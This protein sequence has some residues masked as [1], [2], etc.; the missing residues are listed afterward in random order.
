MFFILRYRVMVL[1]IFFGAL[2]IA[3]ALIL[4]L[5]EL[6]WYYI[7]GTPLLAL[8]IGMLSSFL[9]DTVW[10]K[11]LREKA[12]WVS[13][14]LG[15]LFFAALFFH[16]RVYNNGSF[17]YKDV[18]GVTRTYIKGY[19]YTPIAKKYKTANPALSSDADLLYEGFGGIEG[20]SYVWTQAS[21]RQTTFQ[22]I[23]S[24]GIVILFLSALLSWIIG[25]AYEKR[26]LDPK[27]AVQDILAKKGESNYEKYERS[28]TA[29]QNDEKYK[30]IKFHVFLSYAS[31]ERKFAE[32]V[33]YSLT[34]CGYMVFFDRN[35]LPPGMEY[36]AAIRAAIMSSDI[37]IFMISPDSVTEGH[38]TMSELRF[39]REKW[40]AASGFLLPVMTV[41]TSFDHIPAYAKSVTVLTPEGSLVAEVTAEVEK[42][43]ESRNHR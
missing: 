20:K 14:V 31:K 34:N 27:M 29:K 5:D 17:R 37:L 7:V 42:L 43:Y 3:L 2:G 12:I 23:I 4:K 1:T 15:L 35:N 16:L 40:P 24:Y 25:V 11:R 32:E 9:T 22:F 8:V 36:N 28:Y 21:I 30:Q 41:T 33:Y 13:L 26:F 10:N 6:K 39:A 38:Y 18:K 19:E